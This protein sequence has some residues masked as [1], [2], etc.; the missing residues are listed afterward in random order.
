MT[1]LKKKD[2]QNLRGKDGAIGQVIIGSKQNPIC[3]PSNSVITVP[4][5]INKIPSKI[6]CL[7]QQARHHNLPLGIVI[8]RFVAT[9]K[10]GSVQ[11]ILINT[12]K[13]NVLI[14]Q[15][16]LAAELFTID[17]IEKIRHRASMERKGDNIN[18]SFWPVTPNTIRV[19]LEQ[20]EATSP[21]ISPSTSSDKPT[22]GPSPNTNATNFDFEAEINCPSFKL[23]M[24][25]EA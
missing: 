23:N 16:M 2:Q 4:G 1:C 24:G 11:V 22:F 7:V 3:V 5:Q 20:A 8:N 14:W 15:P 17:Q 19:Q 9:T 18:I 12:T 25:T 13:Q 21:D 10:A 6:T